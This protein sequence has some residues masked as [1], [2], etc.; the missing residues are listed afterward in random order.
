MNAARTAKPTDNRDAAFLVLVADFDRA[1]KGVRRMERHPRA[2]TDWVQRACAAW[3]T[4]V[5]ALLSGPRPVTPEGKAAFA[6]V[7]LETG[8]LHAYNQDA[9]PDFPL[10]PNLVLMFAALKAAST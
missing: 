9:T 2:S 8:A 4:A 5:A 6:R 7:A 10:D 1:A 3:D